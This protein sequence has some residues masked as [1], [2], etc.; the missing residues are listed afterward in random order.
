M[1]QTWQKGPYNETMCELTQQNGECPFQ[2][3]KV[4]ELPGSIFTHLYLRL[5]LSKYS[6]NT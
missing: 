3:I 1:C 6:I 2:V 4:K 5:V